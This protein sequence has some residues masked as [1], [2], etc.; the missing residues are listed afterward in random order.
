MSFAVAV[1]LAANQAA[2]SAVLPPP[3]HCTVWSV[4][5]AVIVGGVVSSTVKVAAVEEE[6]PHSSVAVKVTSTLPVA[7]QSSD[8]FVGL[9]S[10]VQTILPHSSEA[11]APA[12]VVI[13]AVRSALFPV[14]SHSTVMAL[15]GVSI[16]GPVVSATVIVAVAVVAFPH[17]SVAVKVTIELPVAPHSSEIAL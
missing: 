9:G 1:P 8:K 12:R 13:Q 15:A 5:V 14:P 4:A 11:I 2:K 17:S 6:L 16:D 7:P 10:N 3:S